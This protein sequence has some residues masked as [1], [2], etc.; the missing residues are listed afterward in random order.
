MQFYILSSN[1]LNSEE[2]QKL[3]INHRL[4]G[5]GAIMF[6]FEYLVDR[7]NGLGSYISVPSLA[8]AMG[9]NKKFLLEIIN[10][11][12]LFCSPKDTDIFYSPYL[13]TTLGLPEHPSDE[14]IKECVG[15][16]KST[17]KVKESCKKNQKSSNKVATFSKKVAKIT[18]QLAENQHTHYIE[19]KDKNRDKDI[20]TETTAAAVV[21]TAAPAD[22]LTKMNSIFCD[23]NWLRNIEG[24]TDIKLFSDNGIRK[25]V[26][27]W[28][29]RKLIESGCNDESGYKPRD[30]K[31]Y[32]RNL[33]I[34]GRKTRNEFN[35]LLK[36]NREK[37]KRKALLCPPDNRT[38]GPSEYETVVDGV[39]YARQKE[40]VPMFILSQISQRSQR[41]AASCIISQTNS[42]Q[43]TA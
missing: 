28:F 35:E 11:Y 5:R 12:G 16:W 13:R 22:F 2:M 10:N 37:A 25:Q 41:N 20:N 36:R 21:K 43:Q 27:E 32:L 23:D 6:I 8:R 31:K 7:K 1:F 9:K 30:A 14:E 42:K 24:E 4:E 18:P 39:R 17:K 33:L 40:S 38:S 3:D 26:I 34:A 15:G 29:D 19:H